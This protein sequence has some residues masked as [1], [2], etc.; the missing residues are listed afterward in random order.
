M[1]LC[2]LSLSAFGVYYLYDKKILDFYTYKVLMLLVISSLY[3]EI[4]QYLLI[5][6][7]YILWVYGVL[8]VSKIEVPI[9]K[10]Y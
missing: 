1:S 9:S 7:N 8:T 3:G 10:G 5:A 4:S 6:L 2:G